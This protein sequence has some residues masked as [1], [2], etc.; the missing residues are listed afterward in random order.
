MYDEVVREEVWVAAADGKQLNNWVYR[1]QTQDPVPVFINFS[2]YWFNL[3]GDPSTEGDAFSQYMI[4]YFLPRGY[5]VV[6]SSVR[7]TGHSEGCFNVGGNIEKQDAA[8]VIAYF[9]GQPWSTGNIAAGGKS[10][11]GTT[12]QGAATLSPPA[13]KATFPVSGI[14]EMYKYTYKGGLPYGGLHG[15]TFTPRY[16]WTE[17]VSTDVPPDTQ[18]T[19]VDDVACVDAVLNTVQGPLTAGAG[20]YNEYWQERDYAKD[21][22]GAKPAMFF[23]HGLQD[24]NVKP[25]HILPWL[26]EY[27]GPTKA[28]LHQWTDGQTGGHVYPMRDD[29]NYTFLRFLDET[30]KGIDTGFFEEPS[31]QVEDTTGRWRHEEAWPPESVEWVEWSLS[32]MRPSSSACQT[33]EPAFTDDG[34]P[35]TPSAGSDANQIVYKG[36]ELEAD[37]LLAGVP[38]VDVTVSSDRTVGKIAVSLYDVDPDG[39]YELINWGGLNLRHREDPRDPQPIVPLAMYDVSIEMFPQDTVVKKGHHLVLIMAG[40][41]GSSFVGF[42]SIAYQSTVTVHEAEGALLRLPVQPQD[43]LWLESPQPVEF[44]YCT[45]C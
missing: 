45:A 3:A 4:D 32:C 26:Q 2:P 17:G 29:W 42:E 12:P 25:D 5:A 10:Y 9:A 22:S 37:V 34:N 30:L 44:S 23:V 35:P 11:D 39:E 40:N 16:Y 43:D 19:R 38:S 1:P 14:S 33:M 18:E 21:A 20:D 13:L 8:A 7:G 36:A 41:A 27:G 24:W 28:W 31:V 6:L 15:A